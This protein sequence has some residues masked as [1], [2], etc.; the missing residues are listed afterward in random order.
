MEEILE[1]LEKD[2]RLTPEEIAKMLKKKPQ[3]VKAAIKKYEKDF[4]KIKK[5][6]FFIKTEFPAVFR[7]QIRKI[8]GGNHA[9]CF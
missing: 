9:E 2:G 5:S 3:E 4:N 8:P 1:I 6:S 7:A